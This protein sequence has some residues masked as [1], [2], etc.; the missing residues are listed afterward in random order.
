MMLVHWG[1][2]TNRLPLSI[3]NIGWAWLAYVILGSLG[4]FILVKKIE[5][6]PGYK[7]MNSKIAGSTW[8]LSS[9]G[10][11]T[12]SLGSVIAAFGFDVPFWIFN[13]ILPVALICYGIANGVVA[14]LTSN[15]ISGF[16]AAI[17]FAFALIMFPFLL[18]PTIYLI[19]A[20]AILFV[21]V[22]SALS[23][24]NIDK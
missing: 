2:L 12:F 16:A 10:I 11:S 8:M 3:E 17:S 5:N 21:A 14:L 1:V 23:Q 15:R 4:T 22:M 6:K 19:A 24:K 7:S 9:V 18:S 20:F 13:A